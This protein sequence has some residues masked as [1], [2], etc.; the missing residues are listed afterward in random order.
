MIQRLIFT[1]FVLLLVLAAAAPGSAM[2]QTQTA[3][4]ADVEK[5]L[6][7]LR[8]DLRSEKKQLIA[9]NLPLTDTEATTFWPLYDRYAADMSK[10]YDEFYA[11]IKDTR[12]NK[13]R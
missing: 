8:R 1:C 10:H 3:N 7:L 11:I 13:R 9:L 5:D 4:G 2:A 12:P 6:A